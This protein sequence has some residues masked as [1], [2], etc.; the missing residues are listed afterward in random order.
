M[1]SLFFVLH[2]SFA[3]ITIFPY[4]PG[5]N[6]QRL[7]GA[8][9]TT[10][11][12]STL[13]KALACLRNGDPAQCRSILQALPKTIAEA[14]ESD[15]ATLPPEDVRTIALA[16]NALGQAFFALHQPEYGLDAMQ[17]GTVFL[18]DYLNHT[19]MD[20]ARQPLQIILIGLWQNVAFAAME[21][22]DYTT[23]EEACSAALELATASLPSASPHL[24]SVYFSISALPYRLREWDRAEELIKKAMSIWQNMPN[25][26]LEKIATCM[27]NLGRIYEE[28]GEIDAGITWHRKAVNIRRQLTKIEDLA[29][30]LGNLGVALAQ[31][32]QWDEA[33][34]SLSEA[35][36]AYEKAGLG[37]SRECQGYAANLEICRQ[38]L[39]A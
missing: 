11:N 36:E 31:N 39:N 24:A 33:Y 25:P 5:T 9:M 3:K 14:S 1:D 4:I 21:Q 10:I 8:T 17:Q 35:V 20:I 37:K 2:I 16:F 26:N 23:S 6:N 15:K 38:A 12:N 19:S 29:F 18:S 22:K 27:N 13:E 7:P 30:S 32:G 28:R 34:A